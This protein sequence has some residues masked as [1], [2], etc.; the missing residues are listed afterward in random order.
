MSEAMAKHGISVV[1]PTFNRPNSL[2]LCIDAYLNLRGLA[3]LIIIN[4]GSTVDVDPL[5]DRYSNHPKIK[6]V[7]HS[8]RKGTA[9]SVNEGVRLSSN[10]IVFLTADDIAL[11]ADSLVE[12]LKYA[13]KMIE[14][15]IGCVGGRLFSV[16]YE[17]FRKIS[18]GMLIVDNSSRYPIPR[19]NNPPWVNSV[20]GEIMNSFSAFFKPALAEML[21]GT[22]AVSKE[23]F[24][25][26]GGFDY[27]RYLGNH[28]RE[29]TDF[30]LR[31]LKNGFKLVYDPRIVCFHYHQK[32]GGQRSNIVRY[33]YY[34]MRNHA[35]F[36]SRFF[37]FKTFLMMPLFVMQRAATLFLTSRFNPAFSAAYFQR[38]ATFEAP[39]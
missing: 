19:N 17:T 14:R 13:S 12:C 6:Y 30:H 18:L 25:K 3:E 4:D 35:F 33:E 2:R 1:L 27:K 32:S 23:I 22:A 36:L 28:Y 37:G 11:S 29:E 7:R 34:V 15:E 26:V 21:P 24:L 5:M 39:T 16:S 10:P 31:V 8:K 38:Y 9:Y 20:T